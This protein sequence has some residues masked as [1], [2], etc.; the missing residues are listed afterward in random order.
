M[1]LDSIFLGIVGLIFSVA[2]F[3]SMSMGIA[4]VLMAWALGT[5]AGMCF[6]SVLAPK[7]GDI[8]GNQVFF[9]LKYLKEPAEIISRIRGM[10]EREKYQAAIEA[11]NEML[12]RNPFDPLLFLLLIEVYMDRLNDKKQAAA[13][14]EKY[15]LN[16]QENPKLKVSP[17]NVELLMRYSDICLEQ[18][19]PEPAIA[20]FQNELSRKEY[21][22][23][24]RRTLTLR[25][26]ALM[27]VES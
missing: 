6:A 18:K 13:L 1:N 25:L 24:D 4:G 20:L 14:I 21:S 22:D 8:C 27:K 12:A 15:F 17:E 19:H 10:V 23:P 3:F 5:I 11:T 2:A 9:P 7:I 26:E 16:R